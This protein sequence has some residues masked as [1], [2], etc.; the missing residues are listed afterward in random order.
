MLWYIAFI[1]GLN[2]ALGYLWAAYLRPCPRCAKIRE[3]NAVLS[4]SGTMAT[5]EA[6]PRVERPSVPVESSIA[7]EPATPAATGAEAAAE[8]T[9]AF[10]GAPAEADTIGEPATKPAAD[11]L[12]HNP[13]NGLATREQ[14]EYVLAELSTHD[15][16]NDPATVALVE[17]D[18]IDWIGE[19][20]SEA[21]DERVLMGVSVIVRESLSSQHTAARFGNQQLLLVVPHEDVHQATK[22]AEEMRQRI[23]TTSFIAD[24]RTVQTTVTCALAEV[25]QDRSR[26]QLLEFLKEALSEAKRYGGN[27]TFMHDGKSPTPVVP[28]ELE[29]APQQ[30]AI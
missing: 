28:P 14:A 30:V 21:I 12:P 23:A 27:R 10:A 13:A 24:G 16:K 22:R 8:L 20:T 9:A 11:D 5:P 7:T 3:L 25:S 4:G 1:A 26:D 18:E 19:E 29:V 15:T 2:L 6:K 17:V